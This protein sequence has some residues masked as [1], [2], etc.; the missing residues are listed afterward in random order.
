[1]A[2]LRNGTKGDSNPGSLDCDSGILPYDKVDMPSY[3][4]QEISVHLLFTIFHQ[5]LS[6][7]Y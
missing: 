4:G 5:W 3:I 2:R 7:L 6:E 1:M